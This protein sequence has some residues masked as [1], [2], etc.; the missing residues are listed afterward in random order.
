MNTDPDFDGSDYDRE[1]DHSRLAGQLGKVF[2]V[3][4]DGEWHTIGEVQQIT[5]IRYDGS[6]SKH[7][8]HLRYERFGGFD[9]VKRRCGDASRGLWEYRMTNPPSL[10]VA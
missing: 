1:N 7:F 6:V 2:D 8:R 10:V 4:K 3:M 9:V 5:G